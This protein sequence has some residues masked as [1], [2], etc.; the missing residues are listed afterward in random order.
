M[1]GME[2]SNI[3]ASGI[4]YIEITETTKTLFVDMLQDYDFCYV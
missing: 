4:S 1:I 2:K 3:R